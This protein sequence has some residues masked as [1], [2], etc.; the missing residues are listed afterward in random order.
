LRLQKIGE[1]PVSIGP[2]RFIITQDEK[3]PSDIFKNVQESDRVRWHLPSSTLHESVKSGLVSFN[4]L[5][6]S[7][8]Q[9]GEAKQDTL[10]EVAV[11]DSSLIEK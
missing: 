7:S 2:R 9:V 8:V 6:R 5:C 3:A 10:I 4:F 1:I 11:T